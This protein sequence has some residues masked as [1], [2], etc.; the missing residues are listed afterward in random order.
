MRDMEKGQGDVMITN[1]DSERKI[2]PLQYL[3][4][5]LLLLY[6]FNICSLFYYYYI[7]FILYYYNT[8]N[9]VH[10]K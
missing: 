9:N 7:P 4:A 6:S 3:F 5:I 8:Q 1:C 2:V 10:L